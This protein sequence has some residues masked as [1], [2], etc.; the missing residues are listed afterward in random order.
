MHIPLRNPCHMRNHKTN[1]GYCILV[2]EM[3]IF[4]L[5]PTLEACV[6][7]MLVYCLF[8]PECVSGFFYSVV[9]T[10]FST[11]LLIWVA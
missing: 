7:P 5:S 1:S 6:F 4:F 3:I 10:R 11:D 8:S 9:K 2:T